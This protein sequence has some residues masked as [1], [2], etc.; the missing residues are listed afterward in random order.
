DYTVDGYA[1]HLGRI[2][3]QLGINRVHLV[4][5]D[6]GGPW[7]LT[8]AADHVDQFA[9]V[10]LINIGVL[11]GYRWHYLARIWRTPVLGEFFM[12]MTNLPTLRLV[13]RHGNPRGLP[14]TC[15]SGSAGTTRIPRSNAPCCGSTGPPTP[16]RA[17]RTCTDG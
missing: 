8:W 14:P 13:L 17:Q 3:D 2:I 1:R 5:H 10:T 6:F 4:L 7:G 16:Q 9:S 11:R 12:R 15:W